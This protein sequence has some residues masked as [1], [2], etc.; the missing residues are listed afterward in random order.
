MDVAFHA[1]V[2]SMCVSLAS[3]VCVGLLPWFGAKGNAFKADDLAAFA[4]GVM[5]ADAT[6]HQLPH[7][8]ERG[9]D[10]GIAC[11]LG[12]LSFYAVDLM[13]SSIGGGEHTHAHGRP[14]KPNRGEAVE[15]E[16]HKHG[17]DRS[18]GNATHRLIKK[19]ISHRESDMHIQRTGDKTT[20]VM[21]LIADSVHNYTDGLVIGASFV[22]SGVLLGWN[23]AFAMLAHEV[24]QEIG[25]FGIL[26]RSG[27]APAKA[28]LLNF[29]SSLTVVLGT[30]TSLI[31]GAKAASGNHWMAMMEAT[32]AGGFIYL[33]LGHI[34]P[35]LKASLEGKQMFRHV[36]SVLL[37]LCV[38]CLLHGYG[39]CC[40]HD[41]G[42]STHF[43]HV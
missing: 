33:S 39:A 15:T 38:C 17:E 16:K 36:S 31:L 3:M 5:L 11:V 2:A 37:G 13:V 23:T 14:R 41:H 18:T 6:T 20:G 7:A 1:C 42:T 34:L 4:A 29:L 32:T 10:A 19:K 9:G 28:L 30:I 12:M 35:E 8:Y 24:P 25:D 43:R 22:T 40:D 27:F 21:N 26:V